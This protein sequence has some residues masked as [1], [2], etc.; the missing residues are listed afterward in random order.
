[1]LRLFVKIWLFRGL[2][3][4]LANGL[5]FLA[6]EGSEVVFHEGELGGRDADELGDLN[7]REP[8][9]LSYGK[10]KDTSTIIDSEDHAE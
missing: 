8:R 2:C 7:L 9:G 10:D 6:R 1:M 5:V 4:R 3:D